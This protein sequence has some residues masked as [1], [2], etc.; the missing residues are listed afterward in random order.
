LRT[1]ER[2]PASK[3]ILRTSQRA[4]KH[5]MLWG[6]EFKQVRLTL[7]SPPDP[8]VSLLDKARLIGAEANTDGGAKSC[9]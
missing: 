3:K 2:I 1:T 6:A 4:K 8:A 5:S 7:F 9:L